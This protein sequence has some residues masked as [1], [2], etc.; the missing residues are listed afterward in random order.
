MGLHLTIEIFKS[1]RTAHTTFSNSINFLNS[2]KAVDI[3]FSELMA[4][5][6]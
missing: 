1:L 3:N 4:F 2:I 6:P 5:Y